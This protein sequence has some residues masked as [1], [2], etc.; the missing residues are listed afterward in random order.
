VIAE[1]FHLRSRQ[2]TT[3]K[4]T[5][6]LIRSGLLTVATIRHDEL[7]AI[8]D[9]MEQYSDLPMDFADATLVYLARR[10]GRSAI[11]TIDADFATY[12]IEGRKRFRIY[13]AN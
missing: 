3:L 1:V 4:A 2:R 13:P 5:W 11:L 10:E 9:L 6:S 7:P 12:R 8:Q